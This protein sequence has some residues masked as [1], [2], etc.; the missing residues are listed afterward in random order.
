[1]AVRGRGGREI[2]R[3]MRDGELTG[4]GELLP[5]VARSSALCQE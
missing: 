5:N 4:G 1:M 2:E 3:T